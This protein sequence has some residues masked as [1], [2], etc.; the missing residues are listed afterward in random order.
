M[1][2]RLR[3]R[4]SDVPKVTQPASD[5]IEIWTQTTGQRLYYSTY[6]LRFL[7]GARWS[8][9]IKAVRRENFQDFWFLLLNWSLWHWISTVCKEFRVNSNQEHWGQVL[10]GNCGKIFVRR[11]CKPL[12]PQIQAHKNRKQW[13]YLFIFLFKKYI[14]WL[15]YY[16][17]PISPPSLHSILHTPLPHSPPIVHVHGSYL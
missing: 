1:K 17:C 12:A 6:T 4:L 8:H 11:R 7:F 9:F 16:S 3:G 2:L 10:N 5:R 13:F 15:C 14:Y